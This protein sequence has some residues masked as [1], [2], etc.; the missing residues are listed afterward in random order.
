MSTPTKHRPT[1]T[2]EG[3]RLEKLPDGVSFHEVTTQVDDRGTVCELFD[4][5][6]KWRDEPLVFAYM[7]TIRP[8][9]IKGW[10]MHKKH[11]DRYCILQGEME[12]ILYD[13]RHGSPTRGLVSRIVLSEYRR[14]LMNI[15]A[16]IWHAVR[17]L[18]NKDV[19]AVNFPTMP[20]D[21]A[22]PDKYG[23]PL[24][25]ERIPHKFDNP[26]GG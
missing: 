10:G 3:E 25:N 21:Y 22:D 13:E 23:L 26:R 1:V 4:L 7:Y 17:N 20:Y 11:E 15:P 19:V 2:P 12:V 5:R 18:G 24:N 8:G 14:R 9:I 6:W 16:G